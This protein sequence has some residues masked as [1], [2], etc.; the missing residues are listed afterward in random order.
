VLGRS[1]C[2]M[3]FEKHRC[4]PTLIHTMKKRLGGKIPYS[5]F[6]IAIRHSRS[7]ASQWF[8]LSKTG[9]SCLKSR[10][11]FDKRFCRWALEK[12][13]L[14]PTCNQPITLED[15]KIDEDGRAVHEECYVKQLLARP[16]DPPHAAHRMIARPDKPLRL[17]L[18]LPFPPVER[19]RR[20]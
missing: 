14:C 12:V 8:L 16:A 13:M 2:E 3:A 9:K 11:L 20:K 17:A 19:S 5:A 1:W 4:R 7:G 15:A 6:C 18:N 10:S